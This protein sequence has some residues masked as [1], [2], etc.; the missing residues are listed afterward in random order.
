MFDFIL[1][2]SFHTIRKMLS[3]KADILEEPDF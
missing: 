2:M 3:H 1:H